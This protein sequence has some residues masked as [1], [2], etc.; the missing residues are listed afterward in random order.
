M[1]N[2]HGIEPQLSRKKYPSRKAEISEVS[3][4]SPLQGVVRP[5]DLLLEINGVRPRD[6]ID[7]LWL[8]EEERID[9]LLERE[10]RNYRIQL[11]KRGGR[12]L[13][14]TFRHPL[15]DAILTCKN[16]CIFCFVDQLPSGLRPS[17]YL[18]D[19]DYRLSFLDGNF[20]TLAGLPKKELRRIVNLRLSPLYY[21]LHSTDP[22]HRDY[23]MGTAHSRGSLRKLRY[24]LKKGIEIHLQV[25]LCPGINDGRRLERIFHDVLDNYPAAS[26]GVVPVG[27]TRYRGNL[28]ETINPVEEKLAQE[29]LEQVD[30]FQKISL[31]KKGRRLFFAAD[32]FYLM[33]GEDLP[34][35]EEYEDYPQLENG[36]GLSRK[37]I[38]DFRTSLRARGVP[39]MGRGITIL[40]GVLGGKVLRLAMAGTG[41]AEASW[42]QIRPLGNILLGESITVSGL[43]SGIDIIKGLEADPIAGEIALVPATQLREGRFLDSMELEEVSKRIGKTIIPVPA[44]GSSLVE[45]LHE[46]TVWKGG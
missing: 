30:R 11:K 38:D 7:Y 43:L 5:G 10:G 2:S 20:V 21:S 16:R 29:V 33:L 31:K 14:L 24:L 3:E 36:I 19:D 28:R 1:V 17:L 37:F 35:G 32:E 13:G 25:V 4:D 23:M 39:E 15:F 45:V 42:L 44:D 18:K 27:L 40:T 6:I 26:L 9:L 46:V 41:L 34:R 8:Q 22:D 12:P